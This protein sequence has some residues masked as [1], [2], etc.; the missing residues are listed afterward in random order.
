MRQWFCPFI[1][2]PGLQGL[3]TK[4]I[5]YLAL[6]WPMTINYILESYVQ[7]KYCSKKYRSIRSHHLELFTG[8]ENSMTLKYQLY[9]FTDNPENNY[10]WFLG[11][12]MTSTAS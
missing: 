1:T 9:T 2:S 11:C 7:S 3:S 5:E 6:F 4:L 8:H 10:I 12:Q